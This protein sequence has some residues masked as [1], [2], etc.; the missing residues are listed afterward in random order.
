MHEVVTLAYLFAAG[1]EPEPPQRPSS[2]RRRRHR[3]RTRAALGWLLLATG[4]VLQRAGARLSGTAPA[5][6]P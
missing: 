2:P 5:V 3:S 6:A 1:V 4:G